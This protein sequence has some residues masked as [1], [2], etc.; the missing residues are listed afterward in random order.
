VRDAVLRP[1]NVTPPR[2]MSVAGDDRTIMH[3]A[4][5][6]VSA[7]HHARQVVL[8][9]QRRRHQELESNWHGYRRLDR[10]RR[11]RRPADR[12]DA[13][14]KMLPGVSMRRFPGAFFTVTVPP[15]SV[16]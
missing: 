13:R 4:Q 10:R 14:S 3:A 9:A 1:S 5:H 2:S 15:R 8:D 11:R 12:R 7:G 16:T 6:E